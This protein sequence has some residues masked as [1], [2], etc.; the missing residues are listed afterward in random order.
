MYSPYDFF[1]N[2]IIFLQI[3]PASYKKIG[4]FLIGII[5]EVRIKIGQFF[6]YVCG[7]PRKLDNLTWCKMPVKLT[8]RGRAFY[9]IV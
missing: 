9:E 4:E 5:G 3:Y 7:R 6:S 8:R 2:F 1:L